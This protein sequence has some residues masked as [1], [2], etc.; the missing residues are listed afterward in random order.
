MFNL[1]DKEGNHVLAMSDRARRT[2]RPEILEILQSNYKIAVGKI[3]Q[4]EEIG[5]GSV[6]CMLAEMF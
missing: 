5:G 1:L 4:F 6:R 3:D 2:F